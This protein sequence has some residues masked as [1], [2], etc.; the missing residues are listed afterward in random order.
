MN[1]LVNKSLWYHDHT[2][3]FL[4]D[5]YHAPVAVVVYNSER[6]VDIGPGVTPM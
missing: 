6:L 1:P 3:L 5:V 4:N 2:Y